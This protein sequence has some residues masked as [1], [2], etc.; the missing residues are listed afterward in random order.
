MVAPGTLDEQVQTTLARKAT[1][2]HEVMGSAQGVSVVDVE[3]E[4]AAPAR[5]ITDIAGEVV[6][7]QLRSKAVG[8]AGRREN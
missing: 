8:A 7:S 4:A 2:L 6:A 3:G 1:V 5:I